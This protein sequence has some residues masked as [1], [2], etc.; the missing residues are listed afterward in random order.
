MWGYIKKIFHFVIFS[1]L[2]EGAI[3]VGYLSLD[4][5][6]PQNEFE[7]L[8]MATCMTPGVMAALGVLSL[9]KTQRKRQNSRYEQEPISI[10]ALATLGIVMVASVVGV[11]IGASALVNDLYSF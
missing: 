1:F 8:K 4:G 11:A 9:I 2:L 3:V 5:L 10:G 6:L 7:Y